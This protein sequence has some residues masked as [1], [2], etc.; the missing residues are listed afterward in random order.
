MLSIKCALSIKFK[1]AR[2]EH[3]KSIYIYIII[4]YNNIYKIAMLGLFIV[5]TMTFSFTKYSREKELYGS[6][7]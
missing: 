1:N 6:N 4:I 5:V 7:T 2:V 3:C